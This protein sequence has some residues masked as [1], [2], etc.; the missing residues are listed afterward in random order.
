MVDCDGCPKDEKK[1]LLQEH[2]DSFSGDGPANRT[3]GRAPPPTEDKKPKVGRLEK[4]ID[5]KDS[6][7]CSSKA[8]SLN[9]KV[10]QDGLART[11]DG[12]DDSIAS[13]GLA[14]AAVMK[15]IG[16]F[17]PIEP[18]QIQV[19]LKEGEEADVFTFSRTWLVPRLV[20]E[21]SS[22]RLALRNVS[23]LV[24][25]KDLSCE[26][27]LIGLPVLR[28]LEI[29]SRTMLERNRA[30]LDGTDCSSVGITTATDNVGTLGRL[31]VAR[32]DQLHAQTNAGSAEDEDQ[33]N[34]ENEE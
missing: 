20:L 16:S 1:R 27:L 15:G 34:D 33:S 10:C 12:S 19:A 5:A 30:I 32:L 26:D 17:E 2:F 18:V 4:K 31:M 22:G 24:A 6:P 8:F 3:R 7:S 28:H 23:F 21:L 11:D 13:P 25:D 29:D 9:G 14:Q